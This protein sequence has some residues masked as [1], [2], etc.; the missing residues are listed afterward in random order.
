MDRKKLIILSIVVTICIISAVTYLIYNNDSKQADKDYMCAGAPILAEENAILCV[1]TFI[2]NSDII[3]LDI[4]NPIEIR[5]FSD[6]WTV[7]FEIE[8]E[9]DSLSPMLSFNVHKDDGHTYLVPR[10]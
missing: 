9:P 4:Y 1:Q 3:I 2:R 6:Y 7:A 10:L 5:E 8:Q